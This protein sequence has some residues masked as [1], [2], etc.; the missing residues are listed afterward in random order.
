MSNVHSR[1][2]HSLEVASVGRSLGN[3]VGPSLDMDG[4]DGGFRLTDRD[5]G[6]DVVA[7]A[8]VAHDLGNPPFGHSGEDA[9]AAFYRANL[10]TRPVGS[11]LSRRN[12]CSSFMNSKAMH[13][14]FGSSR[15]Q[16]CPAPQGCA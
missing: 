8:C 9:I 14:A 4:A 6:G 2:T 7:A 11:W 12:K 1:L 5:V 10:P 16:A 15:A 3:A 13:K